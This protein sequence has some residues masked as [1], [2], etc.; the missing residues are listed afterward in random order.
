[1]LIV[2]YRGTGL[3]GGQSDAGKVVDDALIMIEDAQRQLPKGTPVLYYGVSMG[4]LFS[5]AL[6]R[7]VK[8]D[9]LILDSAITSM[10]QLVTGQIPWF[11][12]PF[13][14]VRIEDGLAAFDNLSDW[15]SARMPVLMLAGATD[16]LTPV[17][18]SRAIHERLGN[19]DCVVMKMIAGAG[20]AEALASPVG[21]AEVAGFVNRVLEGQACSGK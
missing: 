12:R 14:S 19:P 1:M 20:H 18:F 13:S 7:R 10:D 21:A 3:T 11:I 4:S 16:R 6:A 8:P 17:A 2:D 5:G 15:G 9:G